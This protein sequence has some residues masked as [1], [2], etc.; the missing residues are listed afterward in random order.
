MMKDEEET[1][2][3]NGRCA[4]ERGS[5]GGRRGAVDILILPVPGYI[6]NPYDS[7]PPPPLIL[8]E[9]V[10]VCNYNYK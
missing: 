1:R 5:H 10:Q 2:M 3:A 8:S 9:K 6:L 4:G 7:K